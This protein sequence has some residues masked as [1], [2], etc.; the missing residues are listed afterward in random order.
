MD[1]KFQSTVLITNKFDDMTYF[2]KSVLKQEID[3]DFGNCIGFKCGLSIWELKPEYPISKALGNT[4]NK[5]LN[6]NLEICFETEDLDKIVS[7]INDKNI[8]YLHGIIEE[9]WGQRTIRIYDPEENLVEI[10]ESTSCFVKRFHRSGM[11]AEE[12][13]TRT[14][15][16]VDLVSVIISSN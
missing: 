12:I 16:P 1:I 15:V 3:L 7:E 13:A 2:Y 9:K 14:S 6:R 11:K 4:F 8:S 10:G 5:N